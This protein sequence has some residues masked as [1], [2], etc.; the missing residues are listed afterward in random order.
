[1]VAGAPTGLPAG[2]LT[3]LATAALDGAA[4]L[5]GFLDVSGAI[6]Y[7]NRAACTEVG[8][9]PDEALRLRIF[10]LL[11]SL[12]AEL[13]SSRWIEFRRGGRFRFVDRMRR[14]DGSFFPVDV[15]A[16]LVVQDGVEYALVVARDITERRQLEREL[17]ESRDF[18]SQVVQ[19]AEEGV[20][21]VDRQ[22]RY[23]AR[24]RFMED[25]TGIPTEGLLG[26]S[27]LERDVPQ[28]DA[29]I[30]FIETALAG[31]TVRSG[32]IK[33]LVKPG[34]PEKWVQTT[35]SPLRDEA[36]AVT[37]VIMIVHDVTERRETEREQR[38]L[39]VRLLEAQKLET[40]G[41]LAGGVAHDFNNLLVGVLGNAGLL[42]GDE[43]LSPRQRVRVSEIELAARRAAELTRQMLA[44]SGRGRVAVAPLDLTALV[45]ES[46]DLVRAAVPRTVVLSLA[47]AEGLPSVTANRSQLQQVAMN[48]VINAG[49]AVAEGGGTVRVTTCAVELDEEEVGGVDPAGGKLAA[50]SYVALE[51]TDT[52][53]G[54]DAEVVARV[55]E[56]FFST[57]GAGRGLGLSSVFGIVRGHRGALRVVSEPG[58]GT[59]FRVLLPAAPGGLTV[60]AGP[61]A[62]VLPAAPASGKAA[63]GT[64]RQAGV[65][66]I[67]L[68]EDEAAVTRTVEQMLEAF[69]FVAT[70]A[71]DGQAALDAY[72]AAGPDAF[73]AV[74]LDLAMPRLDGTEAYRR[75]RASDPTLPI[76]V[77]SG[78]PYGDVPLPE[79]A[80][81]TFLAKPYAPV[82]LRQAL[83]RLLGPGP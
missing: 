21:V 18:F 41:V 26:S 3:T 25:L 36:G 19:Y 74:V 71:S 50:G 17:R 47:L 8:V 42:L 70:I 77:T 52:G 57:K 48:L 67:L 7:A 58:R 56:P 65:R 60:D 44:Y 32:D 68:V 15:Q 78:Y 61:L 35:Y 31:T 1:M 82:A 66:A 10:D 40:L 4:D 27:V 49:E 30:R 20:V 9:T 62:S 24:N 23:L 28:L 22:F 13:W 73:V 39:E 34:L 6:R 38:Q 64:A 45:E 43:L 51:V 72:D 69:G 14:R 59:T 81:A 29:L 33:V 11:P 37:G 79:D 80:H 76:L 83:D 75:L 12:T 46:V 2:Q 54:M 5:I 55:F 53:S 63:A 16:S